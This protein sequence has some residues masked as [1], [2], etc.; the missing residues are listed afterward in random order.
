MVTI[1]N[2]DGVH[3]GHQAV[4]AEA[5]K[6][7]DRLKLPLVAVTFEPHPRAVLRPKEAPVRLTHIKEKAALLAHYG[8]DAVYVLRFT[9]AFAK[10]TPEDFV[11][12]ILLHGLHAR[13]VIVGEDFSFGRDRAA[14]I[15]ALR[16]MG[17]EEGYTVT[18]LT[19]VKVAGEVCSSTRIR[20]ALAAGD[21]ATAQTLLGRPLALTPRE[22][23]QWLKVLKNGE[24]QVEIAYT[25]EHTTG[26]V[27]VHDGQLTW[28]SAHPKGVRLLVICGV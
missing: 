9:K 23:P 6:Q 2:F 10:T 24:Y 26:T 1:G 22:R 16:A 7:A 5:R 27:N 20:T 11:R 4:L 14:G 19:P 12:G 25:D 17:A 13:A 28:T 21:V 3:Q 18:T 15:A 8:V